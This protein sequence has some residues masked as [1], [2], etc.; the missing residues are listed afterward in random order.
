MVEF[1]RRPEP[2]TFDRV[3]RLRVRDGA[4]IERTATAQSTGRLKSWRARCPTVLVAAK[5]H[6][7]MGE[8]RQSWSTW[9]AGE[10]I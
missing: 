4:A 5:A 8:Q 3:S 7:A 2:N 6:P 10:P 1:A 9:R